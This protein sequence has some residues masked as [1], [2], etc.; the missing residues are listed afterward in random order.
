MK[1]GVAFIPNFIDIIIDDAYGILKNLVDQR[2][3]MFT[4]VFT[5]LTKSGNTIWFIN[6][7]YPNRDLFLSH[8]RGEDLSSWNDLY[9]QATASAEEIGFPY[10]KKCK[11]QVYFKFNIMNT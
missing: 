6:E 2:G 10:K 7:K 5:S 9:N 11:F 4:K 3:N 1:K 8:K